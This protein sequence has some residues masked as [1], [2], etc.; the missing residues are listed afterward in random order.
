MFSGK[1]YTA[2]KNF[3]RPPVATE[4]SFLYGPKKLGFRPEN[5][6]LAIGP[7]I[8]SMARFLP[9]ARWFISNLQINC[10]TFC[11]R[12]T[13]V[14]VK[15][16]LANVPKSFHPPHCG[17]GHRLSVTALELSAVHWTT[18]QA[19]LKPPLQTSRVTSVLLRGVAARK[20]QLRGQ[21]IRNM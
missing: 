21:E 11:F 2:D 13:P 6:F 8:L 4:V 18:R 17:W 16:K 9:S 1:V 12:V 3:T 14:F 7:Q 5:P 15:K 19:P 10:S 20:K